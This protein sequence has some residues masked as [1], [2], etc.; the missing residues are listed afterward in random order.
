M[1]GWNKTNSLWLARALGI[2]AVFALSFAFVGRDMA[3]DDY[4]PWVAPEDATKVK[5]PVPADPE[6]VAAG[7]QTYRDNCLFC[8]GEKGAG[9][10]PIGASLKV[11]PSD[12][13]DAKMMSAETDGSLFWKMTEGR[14]PMPPWKEALSEKERWQVVN[15]L[16][17][18]TEKANA[19]P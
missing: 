17:K 11:K 10:G 6:N 19:K 5:N 2:C 12:F 1:T 18:L 15:Y 14:G 13:T 7:E 9:D 4:K 3:A 16:R 8:H